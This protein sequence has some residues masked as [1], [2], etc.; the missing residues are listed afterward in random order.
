MHIPRKVSKR[1]VQRRP[2]LAQR[3]HALGHEGRGRIYCIHR[4]PEPENADRNAAH[5]HPA[6]R[7]GR[8]RVRPSHP[9]G[10]SMKT[11]VAHLGVT[12]NMKLFSS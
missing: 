2:T 8:D 4:H 1:C 12:V 11:R 3:C 9:V 6:G 10:A 7:D 5:A